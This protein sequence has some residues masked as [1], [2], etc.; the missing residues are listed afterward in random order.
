MKQPARTDVACVYSRFAVR[1]A[2]LM[3]LLKLGYK[4][5]LRSVRCPQR[6]NAGKLRAA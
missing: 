6:K 5:V 2:A 3:L 4:S 1:S